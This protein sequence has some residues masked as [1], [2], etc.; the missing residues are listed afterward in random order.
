[1]LVVYIKPLIIYAVVTFTATVSL[2]NITIRVN[3][4]ETF[5]VCLRAVNRGSTPLN[6]SV[7]LDIS[8]KF[9]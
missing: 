7:W 3:E 8:G 4:G 6:F 2:A 1:M 9:Y 5:E